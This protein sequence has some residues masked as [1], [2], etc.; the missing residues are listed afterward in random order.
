MGSTLLV[1]AAIVLAMA[2]QATIILLAHRLYQI[3]S[4]LCP[5]CRRRVQAPAVE[6]C[7]SPDS[8]AR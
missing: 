6:L 7:D 3:H 4:V 1:V 2:G 5:E 8:T